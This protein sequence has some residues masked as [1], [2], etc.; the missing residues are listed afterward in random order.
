M[1]KMMGS[2]KITKESIIIDDQEFELIQTDNHPIDPCIGCHFELLN[3]CPKELQ[4]SDSMVYK[5][6]GGSDETK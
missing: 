1:E 5:L 4:C 2:L 3:H 6:K